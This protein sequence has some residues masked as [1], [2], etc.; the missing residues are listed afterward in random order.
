MPLSAGA[1]TTAAPGSASAGFHSVPRPRRR[2][3][4]RR[5]RD[6]RTCAV[7]ASCVARVSAAHPG[8][9]EMNRAIPGALALL[10]YPGYNYGGGRLH[11]LP[12]ER[13]RARVGAPVFRRGR[14]LDLRP[15]QD[16][17]HRRRSAQRRRRDATTC[18]E[19]TNTPC[20]AS[21]RAAKPCA[22]KAQPAACR[23]RSPRS[24]PRPLRSA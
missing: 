16:S 11:S 19:G 5:R 21:P 23:C 12:R 17:P 22:G 1:L 6:A 7:A 10:V 20:S 2:S 8:L 18:A 13:G 24:G 3:A 9:F 14:R 4:R 15:S